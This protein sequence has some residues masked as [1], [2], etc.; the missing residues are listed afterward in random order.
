MLTKVNIKDLREGIQQASY[1]LDTKTGPGS[2][3]YLIAKQAK[4]SPATVGQ[5][6]KSCLYLYSTNLGL[7]RTLLKI[8]AEVT[9][10]GSTLIPPKL[11]QSI[12]QSL[13]AEDTIEIGLSPSG[14]RLQVKYGTL[15]SEIAVHA[16]GEKAGTVL[17]AFPFDAKSITTIS[18]ASLVDIITRTLFC[19]ASG[20]SSISEGPWLASLL[21]ETGDGTVM[22]TGTNRIIAGQAEVLDQLVKGGFS[23]GIHRDALTALK[24]ILA[25]KKE[26]E[27][28]IANVTG[29]DGT[30]NEILFRF[31]DVILG[32][33]QLAKGYPKAVG[34]VFTVP[35]GFHRATINRKV[36][37]SVFGRLS[38]FAEKN[39][40][41]ISFKEDK[42]T[43]LTKGYNS[44][45]QE[46]VA[47][48]EKN[49]HETTVGLGIADTINVL[50]VMASEDVVLHYGTDADH[51]HFQEGDANFKYVLSP[52]QVSWIAK[53]KG[54]A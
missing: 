1:T 23:G 49:L 15:K 17:Q 20:T 34:K 5:E 51:V 26:E 32:I 52:A 4:P 30:S 10:S 54:K 44:V 36:L 45:F 48:T 7:A 6:D 39:A 19:T 9:K 13:P 42:V 53:T 24:A 33:R 3:L 25:K 50:S 16:D 18:A 21:L 28:T 12:L 38:A 43:V 11:L 41:S 47:T 31:S 35:T 8:P 14:A 29:G 27:V 37:L 22:G 2:N 40:F 46:Q